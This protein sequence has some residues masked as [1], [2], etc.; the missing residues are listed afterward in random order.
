LHA[1]KGSKVCRVVMSS[2]RHC[3][4]WG[5]GSSKRMRRPCLNRLRGQGSRRAY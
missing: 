3:S 4:A 5:L 1:P 2:S